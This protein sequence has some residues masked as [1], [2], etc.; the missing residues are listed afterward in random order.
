MQI[1]VNSSAQISFEPFATRGLE[2]PF[3]FWGGKVWRGANL[4]ASM[5][6]SV[7]VFRLAGTP[8]PGLA[9]LQLRLLQPSR[10]QP[11]SSAG[12]RKGQERNL[13][14]PSSGEIETQHIVYI[15]GVP[16]CSGSTYS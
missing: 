14:V 16:E 13:G 11:H 7:A 2:D 4:W 3:L 9:P 12:T 10:L 8:F 15:S 5:G 1:S 6:E